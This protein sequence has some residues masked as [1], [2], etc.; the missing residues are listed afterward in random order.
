VQAIGGTT[1]FFVYVF[2]AILSLFAPKLGHEDMSRPAL[3]RKGA[4]VA[5]IVA[6]VILM[7]G[8]QGGQK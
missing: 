4:A 2:G 3:L 5:L 8:E 6:G 7:G 1:S